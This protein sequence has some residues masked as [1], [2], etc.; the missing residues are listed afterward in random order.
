MLL[1]LLYPGRYGTMP[2]FGFG[3][4]SA[5]FWVSPGC[6]SHRHFRATGDAQDHFISD[7]RF[8]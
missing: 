3:L 4:G 2:H 1:L 6:S 5:E 7:V 8:V